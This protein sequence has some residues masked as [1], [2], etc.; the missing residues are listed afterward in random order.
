MKVLQMV[1]SLRVGGAEKLVSDL[2]V[3][4][5]E[6]GIETDVA[7]FC[8]EETIFS[9]ELRRNRVKIIAVRP[10]DGMYSL[11]RVVELKRLLK[12]YDI[13]HTHTTPAQ[14][15]A[16]M[17]SAGTRCRLV[18]TEH[19]TNNRR[20]ES[21][22]WRPFDRLMYGRYDAIVGCSEETTESLRRYLPNIA[23]KLTTIF[24]GVDIE[25]IQTAESCK[26]IAQGLPKRTNVVMVGR[27]CYPKDQKAIV[28]AAALMSED[29][30][31]WFAGDGP[32]LSACQSLA[33]KT[34]VG[35][36]CHFMGSRSDI[37]SILQAAD[38]YVHSSQWEGLPLSIL[39]AMAAGLPVIATDAKGIRDIVRGAGVLVPPSDPEALAHAL[40]NLDRDRTSTA[41]E[42][43][44]KD[45]DL[46]TMTQKYIEIYQ[47]VL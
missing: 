19:S 6:A 7:V 43:R 16:A 45:Y 11:N 8:N 2:A 29:F 12:K 35:D 28:R 1:A 32:E 4:L 37:A 18:T 26:E 39:E 47:R 9:G 27:M 41:C 24:N 42:E 15:A 34:G 17:A 40:L 13:A 44:V 21:K 33:E 14:L 36:R 5:N 10:T 23:P 31:F 30:H 22:V 20:R 3:A 25:R 46:P 38:V